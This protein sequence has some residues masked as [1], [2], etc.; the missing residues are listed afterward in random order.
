MPLQLQ[1]G[2]ERVTVQASPAVY[3]RVIAALDGSLRATS[4][5]SLRVP[6][7]HAR[8]RA[9]ARRNG[10]RVGSR[11][12]VQRQLLSRYRDWERSARSHGV[13]ATAPKND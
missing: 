8:A 6:R 10:F 5:V 11:G 7:H 9:W 1:V 12:P 3:A 4:L 2:P 13:A